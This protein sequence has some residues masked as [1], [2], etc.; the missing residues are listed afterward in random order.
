VRG[1]FFNLPNSISLTRIPLSAAAGV[2]LLSSRSVAA[3]AFAAA[4]VLTDWL[5]GW[6]ARAT[7]SESDWGRILD[8]LADKL[9]FA[10]FGIC[11]VIQG[12]I[13]LWTLVFIAGRDA[14][15][16]AGALVLARRLV[17]PPASTLPGKVSTVLLSCWM[18]RQTASP[19][20]PAI[21]GLDW[22]G[23]L[24]MASL[25]VSTAVYARSALAGAG[26]AA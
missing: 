7:R 9:G 21:A 18:L 11:L 24:A 4:A 17:S 25:A 19:A 15:V 23:L 26:R 20:V 10:F 16:G 12:R 14:A 3:L 1:P 22:L 13:P 5:D 2:L 8:P 6:S